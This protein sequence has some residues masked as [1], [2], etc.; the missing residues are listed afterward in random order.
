MW[1]EIRRIVREG[2]LSQMAKLHLLV[3][4]VL[5]MAM[6]FAVEVL[7]KNQVQA[8]A[9]LAVG[10]QSQSYLESQA[11]FLNEARSTGLDWEQRLTGMQ[12]RLPLEITAASLDEVRAALLFLEESLQFVEFPEED[13][14]YLKGVAEELDE[15]S[16]ELDGR[17]KALAALLDK[18]ALDPAQANRTVAEVRAWKAETMAHLKR[19]H[20]LFTSLRVEP[21]RSHGEDDALG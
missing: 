10:I 12:N 5:T 2:R 18:N 7:F 20:W 8:A 6:F 15:L 1:E 3:S 4:F 13:Q 17:S 11:A 9:K 19:L 21:K 16:A 14:P